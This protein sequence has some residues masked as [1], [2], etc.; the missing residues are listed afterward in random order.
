MVVHCDRAWAA[1]AGDG[2]LALGRIPVK[3]GGAM[4]GMERRRVERPL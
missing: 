2:V 4:V 3:A 1:M